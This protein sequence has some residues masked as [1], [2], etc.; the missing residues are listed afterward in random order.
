MA[1]KKH[2]K[3][4]AQKKSAQDKDTVVGEWRVTKREVLRVV[5]RDYNGQ[6]LV[7]VRRWYRDAKGKPCPGKGVSCRPWDLERLR[8]ALRKADRL[9]N[10][11][12]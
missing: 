11:R 6:K 2:A 4:L 5:V 3:S 1:E 7:D 8:K 10:G 12:P 9:L